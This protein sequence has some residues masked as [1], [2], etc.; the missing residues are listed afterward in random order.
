MEVV[1]VY[2]AHEEKIWDCYQLF[3]KLINY[4]Y[5]P[6]GDEEIEDYLMLHEEQQVDNLIVNHNKKG[7][8]FLDS[9]WP[10]KS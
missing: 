7:K 4:K 8:G 9:I 5:N 2:T 10:F 3:W 1:E 6:Y